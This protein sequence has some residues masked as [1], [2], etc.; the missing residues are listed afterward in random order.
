MPKIASFMALV[1]VFCGLM[2]IYQAWLIAYKERLDLLNGYQP[3]RLSADKRSYFARG[4]GQGLALIGGGLALTGLGLLL[5][6]SLWSWAFFILG[7][8]L[9][10]A[11]VI[12]TNQRYHGLF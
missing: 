10:L 8:V 12:R 6:Q 11:W 7:F 3:G 5:T 2:I 9:G 4:M 1:M